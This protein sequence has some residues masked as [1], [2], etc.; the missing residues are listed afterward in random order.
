MT[1]RMKVNGV[2]ELIKDGAESTW[3]Y[4]LTAGHHSI[5]QDRPFKSRTSAIRHARKIARQFGIHISK[6]DDAN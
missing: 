5:R 4:D 1:T 6:V 2:L 3:R